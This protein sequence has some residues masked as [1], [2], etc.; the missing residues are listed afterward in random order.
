MR[1]L[2][3]LTAALVAVLMICSSCVRKEEPQV[4]T[5]DALTEVN[6]L[7]ELF[8][9]EVPDAP[10]S[11][12][13]TLHELRAMLRKLDEKGI[14]GQLLIVGKKNFVSRENIVVE[15]DNGDVLI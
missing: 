9:G 7:V 8:A 14:R 2:I 3:G 12:G 15:L 11:R 13:G 6:R 5:P 10:G 1:R 4:E